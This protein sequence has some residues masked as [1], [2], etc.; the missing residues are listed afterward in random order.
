MIEINLLPEGQRKKSFA[1][2][3]LLQIGQKR[4]VMLGV[5]LWLIPHIFLQILIISNSVRLKFAES[6]F[7]KIQPQKAK[8]DEVKSLL[9]TIKAQE[10]LMARLLAQRFICAAKLNSINDILP[11]GVWL[12][13]LSLAKEGCEIK[14]SSVSLAGQ[15][16]TQIR[17]FL[18]ALKNDPAL[19]KDF[20]RLELVTIQRRK[21]SSQE[22]VDFVI[23][24]QSKEK[25]EK[26]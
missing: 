11:E 25:S 19:L 12:T 21:I 16:I 4:M 13:E 6:N 2:Q 18:S 23:S 20:L 7:A 17:K 26:R 5:A 14:G 24:S 22:V 3:A 1:F 15:E 10:N 9:D 8:A